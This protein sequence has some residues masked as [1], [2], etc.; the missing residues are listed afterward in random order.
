MRE[1]G[2]RDQTH[3]EFHVQRKRCKQAI[4]VPVR[5]NVTWHHACRPDSGDERLQREAKVIGRQ[6][7][8]GFGGVK[9]L[10]GQNTVCLRKRHLHHLCERARKLRCS[11]FVKILLLLQK[12]D[13]V[14]KVGIHRVREKEREMT[15]VSDWTSA[16]QTRAPFIWSRI[17]VND[18]PDT[19]LMV[20]LLSDMGVQL[21]VRPSG[22]A[23]LRV[24]HDNLDTIEQRLASQRPPDPPTPPAPTPRSLLP[25]QP[26]S[27]DF[28]ESTQC[29]NSLLAEAH[30]RL[31]SCVITSFRTDAG[32]IMLENELSLFQEETPDSVSAWVS[33]MRTAWSSRLHSKVLDEFFEA[34]DL[35]VVSQDMVKR[36]EVSTSTNR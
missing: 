26:A 27:H 10:E 21:T 7:A 25:P 6:N 32:L 20:A 12:L 14:G 23:C 36:Q 9:P 8:R 31:L 22:S 28:D 4:P 17:S 15:C 35:W 18:R 24:L 1:C 5:R 13:K 29:E 19:S 16:L 33:R 30:E 34:L 2:E 3:L 11:V